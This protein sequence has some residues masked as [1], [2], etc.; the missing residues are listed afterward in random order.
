M[1]S[2]CSFIQGSDLRFSL[3]E[4][5][6]VIGVPF[7]CPFLF[8]VFIGYFEKLKKMRWSFGG[9]DVFT[10]VQMEICAMFH[11]RIVS[12]ISAYVYECSLSLC[13]TRI[14]SSTHEQP[15]QRKRYSG[16]NRTTPTDINPQTPVRPMQL[17]VQKMQNSSTPLNRFLSLIISSL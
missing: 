16:I 8:S 13:N 12:E 10:F 17:F 11:V 14:C 4:L 7:T 9:F 3:L 1:L 15:V 5:C 6:R 2:S